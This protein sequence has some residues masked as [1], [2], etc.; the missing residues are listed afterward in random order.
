[1]AG[2]GVYPYARHK[3]AIEARIARVVGHPVSVGDVALGW[4]PWPQ[5]KL[6]RV[7]LGNGE[8]RIDEIRVASPWTLLSGSE[9]LGKL[10][11]KGADFPVGMVLGLPAFAK[12]KPQQTLARSVRVEDLT[13]HFGPHLEVSGLVGDISFSESGAFE[14]AAFDNVDRSLHIQAQPADQ[15][16]GLSLEGRSWAPGTAELVFPSLQAKG[17]LLNQK[18]LLQNVDTTFLGGLLKGNWLLDWSNGLAMAAEGSYTGIDTK[19]MVA[20]I[21]PLL[22]LEGDVSGTFRFRSGANDWQGLWANLEGAF[23]GEISQGT[24]YGIDPFEAA[25]RS[26]GELRGG[27]TRF[28][29]LQYSVSVTPKQVLG[30]NVRIDAGAATAV[31]QF[32]MPL[33]GGSL[34]GQGDVSFRSSVSTLQVPVRISGNLPDFITASKK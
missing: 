34:T 12:G 26:G 18:L 8:A 24:I 13:L 31:G 1:V 27:V 22:K 9:S 10:V 29:R 7:Q 21:V 19:K 33:G 30:R 25:R 15:G 4:A 23:D 2:G 11:L 16:I 17:V 6:S 3:P 5:L 20:A 32:T 14:K 28:Q